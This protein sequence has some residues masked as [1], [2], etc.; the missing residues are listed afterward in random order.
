MTAV[1]PLRVVRDRDRKHMPTKAGA[2]AASDTRSSNAMLLL[3]V[4]TVLNVIGVVLSL[5][6]I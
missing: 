3:A 4:V 2:R 5:I 6:H 1:G